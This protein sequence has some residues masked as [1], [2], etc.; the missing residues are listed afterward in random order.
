MTTNTDRLIAS[1]DAARE[2]DLAYEYDRRIDEKR[3]LSE[4]REAA[5]EARACGHEFP[6]FDEWTGRTKLKD[7]KASEWQRRWDD[8][9]QD[10]Y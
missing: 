3:L 8:D 9:T 4:Y 7:E 5:A 6:S 2:Q 1:Y 10:L